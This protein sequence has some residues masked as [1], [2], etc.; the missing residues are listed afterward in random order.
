MKRPF[1][2]IGITYLSVQAALFYLHT[3]LISAIFTFVCFIGAIVS[4]FI[5]KNRNLRHT[6]LG[7]CLTAAFASVIFSGYNIFVKQ[8]VIDKYSDREIY[9]TATVLEQPTAQYDTYRY[10]VETESINGKNEK[11]KICLSTINKLNVDEFDRISCV[12]SVKECTKNQMIADGAFLQASVNK[13]FAYIVKKTDDKPLYYR[14]VKLRENFAESFEQNMSQDCASL[15]RAV[16]LGEK[17]AL[18]QEIQNDFTRCGVSFLIVVSGMHLAI[19]SSFVFLCIK[20]IIKNRVLR[21][22]IML[23]CAFSFVAVTGFAPSVVRAGVMLAVVY[24]GKMF[25]RKG[26]SLNSLGI[27]ALILTVPNP[28]AVADVGMLLSFTATLGIILWAKRITVYVMDK[29]TKLKRLKKPVGFAVNLFA[30]SVSASVWTMPFSVLMFGKVSVFSI[31]L[32][33]ILSPAVSVLVACALLAVIL[34]SF[35]IVSFIAYPLTFVCEQLS[36]YVIFIVGTFSDIPFS[37]VNARKPYFY[38]WLALIAVMVVVGYFVKNKANYAVKSAVIS[39][40]VLALGFTVYSVI[41]VNKTVINIYATGGNTV[42][43]KRGKNYSVVSCGGDAANVYSAVSDIMED[44]ALLDF[45]VVPSDSGCGLLYA[46][47]IQTKFDESSVLIY[48][49]KGKNKDNGNVKYFTAN[50]SFTL[51]LNLK[52]K[53]EAVSTE[54]GVYQYIST[55]ST[56]VLL[57]DSNCKAEDILE[58]HRK[59]DYIITDKDGDNL[60]GI[61]GKRIIT[62][63]DDTNAKDC[64]DMIFVRDENLQIV[65]D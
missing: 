4:L 40:C 36:K 5:L 61:C 11:L 26:D 25:M 22:L 10:L 3:D 65:I 17:T 19:I 51:N 58:E 29:F 37:S 21:S 45:L 9:V 24:S 30:V 35:G 63:T 16:L 23:I 46:D 48:D 13:N 1:A 12:L 18:P 59:A 54:N 28:T 52:T 55:E 31:L 41:D 64:E 60:Q 42:T 49:S 39:L 38:I 34:Y 47:I 56:A 50:K 43:V 27:A 62:N 14:A 2:L 53:D 33:V 32:S 8:P 20:K 57:L 7:F 44:T 6:I 15:C